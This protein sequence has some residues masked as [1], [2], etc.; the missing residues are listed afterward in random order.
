[1]IS[2]NEIKEIRSLGQKKFRQERGLFVVEGEKLV[3]EALQSDF[4]IV[5]RY[6]IEDIGEEA[7]ARISQL[8]HPSPDLAVLRIPRN[9]AEF[10]L[11]TDADELVLA[12]DGIHD[13]GNL[14]TIL[15]IADWFGIRTILT[16][17]DTVELY[18]PK[19]VQA[20]MG[21]IFRVK[22]HYGNLAAALKTQTVPVYGTFLEGDGIYDLP[23]TRGGILV[24]GSEADGISP[25]VAAAVTQKLFIPPFPPDQRTGESLNVAVATAI[26][27]NEFRRRVSH[28]S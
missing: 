11:Q 8:T 10:P 12:L 26:A 17:E 16:S 9:D 2:K 15:R 21:A 28:F 1:M 27:C 4:E 13:P 24:M 18:N 7:M 25:Q 3:A 22:V 20:T 19:V 6:R 5:A 23:L 14:G